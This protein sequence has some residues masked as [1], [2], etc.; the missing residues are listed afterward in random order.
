MKF[1]GITVFC[2]CLHR[3]DVF[4]HIM[5]QRTDFFLAFFELLVVFHL[6]IVL[7]FVELNFEFFQFIFPESFHIEHD[8]D[9]YKEKHR[10]KTDHIIREI[11]IRSMILC[12]ITDSNTCDLNRNDRQQP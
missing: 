7:L 9:V 12:H 8:Q 4:L 3:Q 1:F 10:H 11:L 5:P 6:K 2:N